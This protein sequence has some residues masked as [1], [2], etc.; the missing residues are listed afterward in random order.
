MRDLGWWGCANPPR[1]WVVVAC[2]WWGVAAAQK[3]AGGP[4]GDRLMALA[5][6]TATQ[7][8]NPTLPVTLAKSL[9]RQTI[10]VMANYNITH[11]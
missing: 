6:A 3:A 2:R 4:H 7:T 5:R 11:C 1:L 9:P 10:F 8:M